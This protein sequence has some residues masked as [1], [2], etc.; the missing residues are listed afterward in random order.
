MVQT[1]WKYTLES[2][3]MQDIE[4][5]EDA[6]VLTVQNQNGNIC[7]WVRLD[8]TAPKVYRTF[9]VFGTGWNVITGSNFK[10]IG[11]VQLDGGAF[12]F[13]IFEWVLNDNK[14]TD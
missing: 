8:P 13:H 11:T 14:N 6:E 12:V 9:G 7:M 3:E 4:L 2:K 5:P 10:Y 1:I